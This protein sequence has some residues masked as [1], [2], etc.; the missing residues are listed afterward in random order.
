MA[1][2]YTATYNTSGYTEYNKNGEPITIVARRR[3]WKDMDKRLLHP[4]THRV[5]VLQDIDAVEESIK[6]LLLT[7]RGSRVFNMT[8]GCGV[9]DLLFENADDITALLLQREIDVAIQKHEKRVTRLDVKVTFDNES[10][11]NIVITFQ[12]DNG[13]QGVI[14]QKLNAQS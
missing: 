14:N 12:V 8:Y 1:N 7:P 4:I 11:Y 5:M 6:N 10:A 3:L 2:E 9:Q 13:A